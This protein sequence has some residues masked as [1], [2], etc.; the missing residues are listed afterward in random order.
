MSD[1]WKGKNVFITGCT[2]LIGSWITEDLTKKGATVTGLV[3]DN[4]PN[5]NF[6]ILKLKEKI[7]IVHG[8]IERLDNLRRGLSEYDIDTVFHLA[9]QPIVTIA[10]KDPVSTFKANINGTWNVLEA[11]RLLDVKR[12]VIASSDKA[13]GVHD[14]LPYDEGCSLNG[15]FPYDASKACSDILAQTYFKSYGLPVGITRC[16]NI[17]GG[18]DMNFNRIIPETMKNIILDN[19]PPIRS[20]G[21]FVREFFYIKDVVR[22]YLAL[23]ENLNRSEVKGE[24]FNFGSGEPIKIIDLV[25]KMIEISG[26]THLKPDIQNSAKAEIKEQYLSA[27]KAKEILNWE[28]KYNLSEGLKETYKWYKQYL[29]VSP[30]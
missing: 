25:N 26:K 12:V 13:Y 6:D 2:G 3:R 30:N 8:D 14:I 18:G 10:L 27:K 9:A 11:C 24:A 17:Y 4:V 19:N 23:A 7:N 1:F 15:R 28:P 29:N 21:Q 16:G 22:A 20:D 5:N